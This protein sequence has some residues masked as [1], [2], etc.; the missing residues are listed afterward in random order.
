MNIHQKSQSFLVSWLRTL[1]IERFVKKMSE[2][3]TQEF[4]QVKNYIQKMTF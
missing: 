1:D 3:R 4:Q 2:L